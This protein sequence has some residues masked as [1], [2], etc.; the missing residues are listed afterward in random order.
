MKKE[1][2]VEGGW[3]GGGKGRGSIDIVTSCRMQEEEGTTKQS[4]ANITNHD[5]KQSQP[6]LPREIKAGP[7]FSDVYSSL[8]FAE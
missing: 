7:R 5:R 8:H 4:G 6:N 3:G 2:G 1:E